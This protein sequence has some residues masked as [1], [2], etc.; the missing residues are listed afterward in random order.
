MRLISVDA[1]G[2]L[3]LAL[4]KCLKRRGGR[5]L[6]DELSPCMGAESQADATGG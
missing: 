5:A 4:F 2:K 3:F 6:Q 1:V